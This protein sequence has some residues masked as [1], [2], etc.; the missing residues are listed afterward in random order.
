MKASKQQKRGSGGEDREQLAGLNGTLFSDV[1]VSMPPQLGLRCGHQ[2]VITELTV[3]RDISTND[4]FLYT[5]SLDATCAK[6]NYATKQIL[7]EFKSHGKQ[8]ACHAVTLGD[9]LLFTGGHDNC[10]KMWRVFT[11]QPSARENPLLRTWKLAA[12]AEISEDGCR[13]SSLCLNERDQVV[14]AGTM[15]GHLYAFDYKVGCIFYTFYT[16]FKMLH[17]LLTYFT[18]F[19]HANVLNFIR[20]IRFSHAYVAYFICFTLMWHIRYSISQSGK[21][22]PIFKNRKTHH[23][24]QVTCLRLNIE[25]NLLVSSSS[26]CN[27]K[28]WSIKVCSR[29]LSLFFFPNVFISLY[30]F[31]QYFCLF[32][33]NAFISLFFPNV[34]HL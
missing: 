30:F 29:V 13:V 24:R 9:T 19:S 27:I 7:Q 25:N 21:E 34:D 14:F 8:V 2:N 33:S 4:T 6:W 20:F 23:S 15:G 10:V 1:S 31:L 17:L 12:S 28:I 26:D 11:K 16:R 18:R 22:L 5:S 3:R 32:F